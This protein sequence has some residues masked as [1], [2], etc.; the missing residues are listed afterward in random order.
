MT[1]V[2]LPRQFKEYLDLRHSS[3]WQ[4]QKELDVN[5]GTAKL[6]A[7]MFKK[8]PGRVTC[9]NAGGSSVYMTV[10]V[11]ERRTVSVYLMYGIADPDAHNLVTKWSS[12]FG[13][14][15]ENNSIEFNVMRHKLTG[16]PVDSINVIG[17]YTILRA[18]YELW[19]VK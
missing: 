3:D 5:E 4:R 8:F 7:K 14:L 18:Y 2:N 16:S 17:L 19:S 1:T 10:A 12:N 13:G 9:S 15:V 6:L 11:A